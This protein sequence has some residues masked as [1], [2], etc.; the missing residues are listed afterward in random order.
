[1]SRG[2]HLIVLLL[3]AA[4]LILAVAALATARSNQDLQTELQAQQT[5]INK[6]VLSQQIGTNLIRDIAGSAIQNENLR[7]LLARHGFTIQE[8]PGPAAAPA[9]AAT[10][11]STPGTP[12]PRRR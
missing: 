8:T 7:A 6:G 4:C 12:P 3:S 10:P 11:S 2:Q 1:M 9:N 5:E